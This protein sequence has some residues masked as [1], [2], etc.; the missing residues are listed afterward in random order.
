KNYGNYVTVEQELQHV[1]NYVFIQKARFGSKFEV[2]YNVEKDIDK[3]QILRFI[4][5]PIV[6][7]AIIHGVC[8]CTTPG[9]IEINIY[10]EKDSICLAVEDDGMGMSSEKVK[11]LT[12][13]INRTDNLASDRTKSI[14]IRNVNQRIRLTCGD[15]YG[16]TI[17]S[18]Q[19]HGSSFIIKLPMINT[20]EE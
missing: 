14:G 7:N 3:K 17:R 12:E 16:I 4:L 10:Q 2:F 5:Q 8:P 13:Y 6:E 20:R 18:E 11:E 1:Q 9:T 19:N 15:E